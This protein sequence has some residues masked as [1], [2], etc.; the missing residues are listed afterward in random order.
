MTSNR[1][2]RRGISIHPDPKIGRMLLCSLGLHLVVVLIFA[3]VLVPRFHR[4]PQPVY[5]VDLVNLP[6]KNPQAGRP[7]AIR[8]PPAKK[9]E[10]QAPEPP[11]AP[12]PRQETVTLP[13]K[14]EPK[15]QPVKKAVAPKIPPKPAPKPA[16][17]PVPKPAPKANYDDTLAAMEK[18]RQNQERKQEIEEL[19]KKLA[20]MAASDSRNASP[21]PEAPVGMPEGKGNEAGSSQEAWLHEFLKQSWSLSKYQVTRRDLEAKATLIFDPQGNLLDYR[22]L[23]KS[24]DANFDDSVRFAILKAKK[25]PFKPDRRW[26]VEVTFNLKD[27]MDN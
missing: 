25:L 15:P 13:Q 26:E 17:K 14:E 9:P 8:P 22:F 4:A 11:P 3:G 7:E 6:V 12:A 10:V 23:E 5:T 24:G 2:D 19:K 21:V 27:L 1:I 20:A 16:P 18:M